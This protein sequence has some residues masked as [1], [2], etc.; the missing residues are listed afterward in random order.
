MSTTNEKVPAPVGAMET[1]I[2]QSDILKPH[3]M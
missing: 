2:L 1:A 3:V